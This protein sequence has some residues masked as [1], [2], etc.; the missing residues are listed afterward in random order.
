MLNLRV[1]PPV[2][3]A[4][5]ALGMWSASAWGPQ[6]ALAPEVRW[7]AVGM[8]VLIGLAFDGAALLA[9]RAAHTTI[10]PLKPERA[11]ALVTGGVYWLTRN[12]MYVGMA[13]FL[14]AWVVYLSALLP[15][16]GVAVFV[17]YI[18]HFQIRPEEQVLSELFGEDYARY[19]A[20]VRRWL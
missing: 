9:F 17:A 16:A 8:L 10:N 13:L 18:T 5:M 2:V 15:V 4:L 6:W 7:M 12:P 19:A 20:R 11:S 1:P 14:T 3:G